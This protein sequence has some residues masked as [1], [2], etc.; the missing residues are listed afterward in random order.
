M[1]TP[2]LLRQW[3]ACWPDARIEEAFAGRRAVTPREVA[4][5]DALTREERVWVLC[6]CMAAID[7]SAA[8]AFA[9]AEVLRM[10]SPVAGQQDQD[11]L[12]GVL[13]QIL[14]I[15]DLPEGSRADA[16][17]AAWV[18]GW[19]S[20]GD[21]LGPSWLGWRVVRYAASAEAGLG[22]YMATISVAL[23]APSP[24]P[25]IPGLVRALDWL[26]AFADGWTT[27]NGRPAPLRRTRRR[28]RRRA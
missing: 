4:S 17:G 12:R 27:R 1:I 10:L 18:D 3:H 15:G 25:Q 16:Y 5:S 9:V 8:R 24:Q 20:D 2:T 28:R 19:T 6:Q 26:G 23:L 7:E 22:A 21:D 14:A 13:N 11:A